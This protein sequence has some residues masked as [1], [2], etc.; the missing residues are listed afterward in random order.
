[1]IQV[2][3]FEQLMTFFKI[4]SSNAY[5]VI[6]SI[7]SII[8]LFILLLAN[9]F[10]NK[11]ITKILVILV[12][13][14]I[15]GTLIY[16]YHTEIL[17]L[18]DYLMNNIFLLLF[19]PN[20]AVYVLVLIIINIIIIKSMLSDHGSKSTNIL[21]IIFFILFNVIFYLIIDNIIKNNINVYEQLSIYTNS[22]LL[23]LIELSMKLFIIWILLLIIIKI[24]LNLNNHIL[25]KRSTNKNLILDEVSNRGELESLKPMTNYLEINSTNIEDD[26]ENGFNYKEIFENSINYSNLKV[27]NMS[28][29]PKYNIYNDYLD[30]VPI[31]KKVKESNLIETPSMIQKEIV[32]TS[33]NIE[34]ETSVNLHGEFSSNIFNDYKKELKNNY[35]TEE[36]IQ[37]PYY[38]NSFS[39]FN[40][41][42]SNSNYLTIET[43]DTCEDESP[44]SLEI[45]KKTLDDNMQLLFN[46]S[47][48]YMKNIMSDIEKLKNNQDDKNQIK[49]IYDDIKLNQKDLTLRDYNNLIDMLLSVKK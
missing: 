7:A 14:L 32:S 2:N 4:F 49:K 31:R 19:F 12:Y 5:V 47:N 11:K 39:S 10:K 15:F 18:L 9:K 17:K 16:F 35:Q 38:G 48:G 42:D 30:M 1:M 27:E 13:T 45:D 41:I 44:N 43:E 28:D 8:A 33:N 21:N 40:I 23:I 24:S 6:L 3:I 26:Y 37:R 22:D 25:L 34:I 29:E 46:N 20:L 36:V